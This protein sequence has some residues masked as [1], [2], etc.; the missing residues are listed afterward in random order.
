M[1]DW[2]QQASIYKA[3]HEKDTNTI[4]QYQVI[5][6]TLSNGKKIT[7]VVPVFCKPCD[8]ENLSIIDFS[9]S[10]PEKLKADCYWASP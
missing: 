6:L 10:E 8:I 7:A 9:I 4:D 2:K 3:Q 5:S 1:V